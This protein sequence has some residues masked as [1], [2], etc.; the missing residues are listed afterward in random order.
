[1]DFIDLIVDSSDEFLTGH[2]YNRRPKIVGDGKVT[3]NYKQFST[4]SRVF[5]TI[6]G[7]V[8]ADKATYA[9][10]TNDD[11]G[12][13]VGAY[14]RTQNGLIWEIVEVVKNEEAKK[15]NDALRWFKKAVNA[16]CNIRMIEVDD[17]YD[18]ENAYTGD[19]AVRI[20]FNKAVANCVVTESI[21]NADIQYGFVKDSHNKSIEFETTKNMAVSILVTFTD[22]K[23]KKIQIPSYKT[24]ENEI[25]FECNA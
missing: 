23:T 12:F 14:I 4:H 24:V 2:Y 8:R 9:I 18:Q 6:L 3:F 1:M 5:E 10:S 17:L 7:N 16:E 15:N 25:V 19:C 11:C 21:S 22:G 20:D 13:S